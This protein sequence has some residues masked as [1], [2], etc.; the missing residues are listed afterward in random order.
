MAGREVGDAVVVKVLIRGEAIL[1]NAKVLRL[2]EQVSQA[3]PVAV[4]QIVDPQAQH[5]QQLTAGDITF[6]PMFV[7]GDC[8][9]RDGRGA[10]QVTGIETLVETPAPQ[11]DI[12]DALAAF[13]AAVVGGFVSPESAEDTLAEGGRTAPSPLRRPLDGS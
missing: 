3:H 5:E 11:V 7:R 4:A 9:F 12:G 13:Q 6:L 1:A 8:M 2:A 10:S